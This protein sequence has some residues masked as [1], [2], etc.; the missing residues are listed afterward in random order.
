MLSNEPKPSQIFGQGQYTRVILLTES[1][2]AAVDRVS[3]LIKDEAEKKATS[4]IMQVAISHSLPGILYHVYC[5]TSLPDIKSKCNFTLL[6]RILD[7]FFSSFFSIWRQISR[8]S[9]CYGGATD[10]ELSFPIKSQ[11]EKPYLTFS[12]SHSQGFSR[13]P[14]SIFKEN[15]PKSTL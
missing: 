14:E 15:L 4:T 6:V 13:S 11:P 10:F 2:P 12:K 9:N 7:F 1:F 8:G 3:V 5:C